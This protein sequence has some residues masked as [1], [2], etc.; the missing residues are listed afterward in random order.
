MVQYTV[1]IPV[2]LI[3][4]I[5]SLSVR[6]R[7][8]LLSV[9]T[10]I[11]QLI[12]HPVSVPLSNP[13]IHQYS[14]QANNRVHELKVEFTAERLKCPPIGIGQQQESSQHLIESSDGIEHTYDQSFH[15]VRTLRTDELKHTSVDQHA[16]ES[17]QC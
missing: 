8:V 16:R 13:Y 9:L 12:S 1:S 15:R 11:T 6:V 5:K 2:Q 7:I 14:N 3:I 4:V 10:D 17:R